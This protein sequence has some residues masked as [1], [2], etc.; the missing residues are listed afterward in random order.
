MSA[1]KFHEGNIKI[2]VD[3][4]KTVWEMIRLIRGAQDDGGFDISD[5]VRDMVFA[6]EMNLL[7]YYAFCCHLCG[8]K[9]DEAD[10]KC[11]ALDVLSCDTNMRME[12]IQCE[13]GGI[14]VTPV[15][16]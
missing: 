7:Y 9:A 6:M 1:F 14:F 3:D 12:G 5:N 13:C 11:A 10:K 8:I 15:P 16:K 4:H 2:E